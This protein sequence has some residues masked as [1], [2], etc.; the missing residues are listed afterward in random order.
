MATVTT[1][2][3]SAQI[4]V[5]DVAIEVFHAIFNSN[6]ILNALVVIANKDLSILY[7]DGYFDVS[8]K[9]INID[10]LT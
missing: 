5:S 7:L 8:K 1:L 4:F 2:I 6:Y 3:H 9:I 10:V